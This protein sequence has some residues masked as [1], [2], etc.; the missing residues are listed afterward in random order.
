ACDQ[1]LLPVGRLGDSRGPRWLLTPRRGHDPLALVVRRGSRIQPE[2]GVRSQDE[3][4]VLIQG[5]ESLAPSAFDSVAEEVA[6]RVFGTDLSRPGFALLD[7]GT[8]LDQPRFRS[9][10]IAMTEALSRVY[11][12]RFGKKL[13][14]HSA[15]WFDQQVTTEAHLDGGPDESVLLL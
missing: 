15:S 4:L 1:G 8:Q 5:V 13:V 14:I 2:G 9:L 12:R 7:L 10:L 3:Y 11:Q 6:A